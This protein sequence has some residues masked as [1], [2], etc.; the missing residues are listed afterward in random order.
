LGIVSASYEFIH[1]IFKD[2]SK[3]I[4]EDVITKGH[5]Q[6]ENLKYRYDKTEEEYLFDGLN[7]ELKGGKKYG[8]TGRS[9]SGKSSLMK[10]LVGLYTPESGSVKIDGVDIAEIKLNSLRDNVNYINQTTTTFNET[11]VYNMLYGNNHITEKQLINKLKKYKLDVVFSELPDGVHSSA[12]T[13]GSN[14]SGGMQKITMLM[15]GILKKSKIVIM[16]EPLTGLDKNTKMKVID[17][18]LAETV[19]KTLIIITHDEEILPH[20]DEVVNINSL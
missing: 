12:G 14:L 20:M 6:F 4:K 18:I 3:R 17:M 15:R 9:G 8:L 10:I 2:D 5:V 16:D 1:N 11:V 7:L 19:G 13:H